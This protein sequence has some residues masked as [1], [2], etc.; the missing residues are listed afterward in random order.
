MLYELVYSSIAAHPMTEG[1]VHLLLDQAR[2]ENE[3]LGISGL[4]IFD[5]ERFLQVLEGEQGAVDT[6]FDAI[7]RDRRHQDIKVFHS[8]AIDGRSFDTWFMA[9]RRL[10]PQYGDD[11]WVNLTAAADA[12][13]AAGTRGS[14]GGRILKLLH[15]LP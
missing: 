9:Y 3:K 10:P 15:G 4:L 2:S 1:D 6:L 8:G 7:M 11:D 14:M 5:G 13:E 12:L